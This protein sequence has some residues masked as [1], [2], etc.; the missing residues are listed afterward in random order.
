[1]IRS[2]WLFIAAFLIVAP[3]ATEP[4]N[5]GNMRAFL[6][7]LPGGNPYSLAPDVMLTFRDATWR[8]DW[9]YPPLAIGLVFPAW[10]L[11]QATGSDPL[12]QLV[13]KLPMLLGALASA[14]LLGSTRLLRNPAVFVL[15]AIL[16]SFDA[17]AMPLI[18]GAYVAA[19]RQRWMLSAAALGF[20]IGL[21]L[22][23]AVLLLALLPWLLRQGSPALAIRYTA[24]TLAVAG[25][26]IS[27]A[28]LD[29][30]DYLRTVATQGSVGPF[31]IS[32]ALGIPVRLARRW[33]DLEYLV[34][35]TPLSIIAGLGVMSCALVA[36]R[37]Q[38]RLLDAMLVTL[39]VFFALSPKLHALYV[40]AACPL[41]L[42]A[43][44]RVI[45][46]F[47]LPGLLW[48][49]LFNGA[50]GARGVFYY[51]A[52]H[53]GQWVDPWVPLGPTVPWLL[54]GGLAAAHCLLCLGS[55][56]RLLDIARSATPLPKPTT[57]NHVLTSPRV[58]AQARSL[59][60]NAIAVGR[61]IAASPTDGCAMVGIGT[62]LN[63]TPAGVA[64]N[65]GM[66]F[67]P[68]STSPPT[69]RPPP[70]SPAPVVGL[71][72]ALLMS[73]KLKVWPAAM[74]WIS[75]VSPTVLLIIVMMEFWVVVFQIC[76]LIRLAI[77]SMTLPLPVSIRIRSGLLDS[78]IVQSIRVK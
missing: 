77:I 34:S 3:V 30:N 72:S 47:W 71:T 46:G 53:T 12:Y 52:P 66:T 21:R 19:V 48:F 74:Q 14:R 44:G 22:Y 73:K 32:A 31:G 78:L 54:A 17:V 29:L 25:I 28:L 58:T 15:A 7:L 62:P 59:L 61:S 4:F 24:A 39:L 51:L 6:D 36:W 23:P 11:F 5:T 10:V 41:A 18:L 38:V 37:R 56:W 13:V 67:P 27:P 50:F 1:M 20:A 26:C 43:H 33:V 76:P 55:A 65:L 49:A 68:A 63:A 57:Q 69:R 45:P 16:G 75:C 8:L 64:L 60:S 70:L 2:Y 9:P 40:V 42:L 35:M